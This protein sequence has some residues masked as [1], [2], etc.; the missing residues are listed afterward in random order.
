MENVGGRRPR[1]PNVRKKRRKKWE[2]EKT[3]LVGMNILWE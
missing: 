1:Q 2:K 3:I